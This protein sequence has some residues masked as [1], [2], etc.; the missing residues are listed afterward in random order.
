MPFF[1][2]DGDMQFDPKV[3]TKGFFLTDF[4]TFIENIETDHFKVVLPRWL[5]NWSP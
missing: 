5:Q 1:S 3:A 4:G 2:L